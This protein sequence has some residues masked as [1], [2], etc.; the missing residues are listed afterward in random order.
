MT[1]T[2]LLEI[3]L[4][5]LPAQMIVPA[6]R[7]LAEKTANFL[8]EERIAYENI[9]TFSTPRRLAILVTG[10]A[11]RQA[12]EEL[13][14]RG[15]SRKIAQNIETGEWTKA[16]E[17]FARGQGATPEDIIFK[18][19]KDEDYA[20][21]EKHIDGQNVSEILPA[22]AEIVASLDFPK[23]MKWGNHSYQYIRPIHWLV[24][25]L[26]GEI[27]PLEVFGIESGRE[28]DGHRFFGHS[29]SI[30]H[31][32]DYEEILADELVIADRSKRKEMI[33]EQIASICQQNQWQ[34]PLEYKEL[35][36]EVTDLVEYPTAFYAK[37]NEDFLQV[38]DIVLQT[39][40]IS[41]QRY[42]PVC[43]L[44][45]EMLPY[46]IGVRN[47]T[48]RNIQEIAQG[49]EKV[50]A[51][52]LADAKFFYEEDQKASIED[53][54]EALE[55]VDF[56]AELGTLADKERRVSAMVPTLAH[57]YELDDQETAQLQRAA[58]IYKFDLVTEMVNEFTELQGEM[59]AIYALEK[60]EDPE[61][62]SA[63]GQ[64]YQP[65]SPEDD[66]PSSRVAKL[67]ALADKLD[68]LIHFF[69]IDLKPTG[70]NDPFAL[71]RQANGVIRII[72]AL[73]QSI[74]FHELIDLI[75]ESLD[76][77]KLDEQFSEQ[78]DSFYA[79]FSERLSQL[80]TQK[81]DIP[82]DIRQAVL[83]AKRDDFVAMIE[84]A[85]IFNEEQSNP[86]FIKTL[87]S[88]N[89]ILNL[90]SKAESEAI[91]DQQFATQSESELYSHLL[92]V[93]EAFSSSVKPDT[94]WTAL[95]SLQPTIDT[96]FDENMVMVDDEAVRSNRL[97]LL[98]NIA[99][100]ANQLADFSLFVY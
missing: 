49:N 77:P 78:A 20:F 100:Y 32:K 3:G 28:T 74:S 19:V 86:N 8:E 41:H 58:K 64:Q 48:D 65:E 11:D 26:D 50:L 45:G 7:Q 24:S 55:R 44:N 87:E 81:D 38:P 17:G 72:H 53:W 51:A 10:M 79:F 25:L 60:G 71:R 80:M 5:D 73:D 95:A 92:R 61:V 43:D 9:K 54:N 57:L 91:D 98:K 68:T 27:V 94:R 69:A 89:R 90:A 37:F 14:V 22:L 46:F 59:G 52:R 82:H 30:S 63:I 84:Q 40:M 34:E 35:L 33:K 56:H 88:I 67:L 15:P 1:H 99:N 75:I 47:G 6:E 97:A 36:D 85:K 42:F 23:N 70:S 21:I 93:Q 18:A 4:E 12:D 29:Q 62:A 96:F 2:Y 16:A 31:A 66:L 76:S 39:S 83:G 13:V